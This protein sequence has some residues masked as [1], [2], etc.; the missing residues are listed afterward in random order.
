MM[1]CARCAAVIPP[2]QEELC[3]YCLSPLCGACWEQWGHCGH[4]EADAL[5]ARVAAWDRPTAAD[6]T[7][8]WPDA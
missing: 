2:G 8:G 1:P 7:A 3:W 4:A 6:L 5:N